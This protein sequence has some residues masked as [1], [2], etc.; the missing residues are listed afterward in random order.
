[1]NPFLRY[2]VPVR[3]NEIVEMAEN[4]DQNRLGSVVGLAEA[5]PDALRKLGPK[6]C[7]ANKRYQSSFDE[8]LTIDRQASGKAELQQIM[9]VSVRGTWVS[10][11]RPE[12]I[13]AVPILLAAVAVACYPMIRDGYVNG[14]SSGLYVIWTQQFLSAFQ[15]GDFFS[16]KTWLSCSSW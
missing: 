13:W 5:I 10:G 14:H 3:V 15:E 8:N 2:D 16:A 9:S 7:S 1:L 6:S 11:K 4:M 12:L